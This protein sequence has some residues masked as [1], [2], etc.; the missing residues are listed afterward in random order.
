MD[1]A[2]TAVLDNQVDGGRNALTSHHQATIASGAQVSASG[3]G[4][5]NEIV[6]RDPALPPSI[7]GTVTP[8]ATTTLN[9][10]LIS[11][12]VC[13]DSVVGLL[14]SCDDGNTADGDGCSA[15]CQDEGC[16]AQTPGWPSV[17]LCDDGLLCTTNTCTNGS[18]QAAALC[19]DGNSCTDD[20]CTGD[21]CLYTNNTGVC[22]DGLSCTAGDTC[23]GGL[24]VGTTTCAPGTFC[25]PFLDQCVAGAST[26]TTSTTTTSTTTTTVAGGLCGNGLVEGAEQCDDGDT[27]WVAGEFCSAS[28]VMLA[29]GDPDDSG[30]VTA[31]DALFVLRSAVHLAS[32]DLCLC[33]V[34][35]GG[36]I[37]ASDALR[38]LRKAV[39]QTVSLACPA[40]F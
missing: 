37:T 26:S 19:D 8:A 17:P 12:D 5:T 14:E 35:D 25:S 4:G 29:C 6:Y 27:L 10:G 28:C 33:D 20:T 18:C 36:S 16:T 2:P 39:G 32:C 3:A 1:L 40:C 24:C 21:G 34:D 7:Q 23:S 31:S 11:C 15:E 30:A 22:D 38:L 13:G 9:P